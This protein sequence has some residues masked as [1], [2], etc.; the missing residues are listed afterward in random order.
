MA[1]KKNIIKE[2][3]K[4]PDKLLLIIPDRLILHF[5]LVLFILLLLFLHLLFIGLNYHKFVHLKTLLIFIHIAYL[6]SFK[7]R[8]LKLLY[9]SFLHLFS[10]LSTTAFSYLFLSPFALILLQL[11]FILFQ[12]HFK[13][14]IFISHILWWVIIFSNILIWLKIFA[15]PVIVFPS[16]LNIFYSIHVQVWILIV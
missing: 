11:L 5:I 13:E 16:I 10:L 8:F 1:N 6:N 15:A 14:F 4:L 3:F 9:L 12:T 2:H 7:I